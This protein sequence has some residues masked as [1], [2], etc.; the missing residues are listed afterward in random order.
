MK[1]VC[2]IITSLEQGGA[3]ASLFRLVAAS[4]DQFTHVVISLADDDVTY[5]SKLMEIG[6]EVICLGMARG[7]FSFG[8]FWQLMKLIKCLRPDVVQTWMYHA[9]FLGGVAARLASV[10]KIYWNVRHSDL[11]R[12]TTKRGTIIVAYICMLL[13]YVVPRKIVFPAQQARRNHVAIGY[14]KSK[15]ICIPNGYDMDVLRPDS[16]AGAQL[17]TELAIDESAFVVAAV[18]RWT[19]E[20]DYPT[21][22]GALGL[23]E[24]EPSCADMKV[25]LV[26]KGME[27]TNSDLI[28]LLNQLTRQD[29]VHLL[30]QR[31]DMVSVF[32]AADLLVLSSNSEAFPNVLAEAMAC[33]VPVVATDVGDAKLIVDRCGWI[34]GPGDSS[35][36]AGNIVKARQALLSDAQA[37]KGC[38]REHIYSHF[39]L[40][41]VVNAYR[42]LWLAE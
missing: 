16:A 3:Q 29:F 13:S 27:R 33:G 9:D 42:E 1:K 32:N 38:A 21:L 23:L 34:S 10:K 26:G 39:S 41:V 2:H 4:R 24:M 31:K 12:A 18:G 15:T 35:A 17:R 36:L 40:G 7:A 19:P 28:G 6:V 22:F 30:G 20:K 5:R 11:N 37:I 25:V 14:K 8:K